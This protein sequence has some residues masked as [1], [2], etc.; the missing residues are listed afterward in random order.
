MSTVYPMV[1]GS[2]ATHF[3]N[4]APRMT[5]TLLLLQKDADAA[6]ALRNVAHATG[7]SL[8]VVSSFQEIV[9]QADE[10]GWGV[11]VLDYAT[12]RD[13][14]RE[15]VASFIKDRPGF[16]VVVW[17]AQLELPW[18]VEAMKW[19]AV[20]VLRKP[21]DNSELSSAVTNAL[22][23]AHERF[24][25]HSEYRQVVARYEA[26]TDSEQAVV[27]MVMR[28]H[29]N[30]EIATH[31]DCSLRTVEARRHK[32]LRAMRKENAVD[33]AVLLSQ[34]HLMNDVLNPP[35]AE[36][37]TEGNELSGPHWASA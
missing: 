18:A 29:T 11:V 9:D 37:P 34:N 3:S 19:G 21:L 36:E 15:Q 14:V 30:K 7:A 32:I 12:F 8:V 20:D 33:L 23:L 31:L 22:G 1:R 28:G 16:S 24:L 6:A 27:T 10:N 2:H 5:P 17:S 35:T 13:D 25:S 4:E 26:L